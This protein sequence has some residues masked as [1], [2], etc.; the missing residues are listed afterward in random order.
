MNGYS[1][2]E[3]GIQRMLMYSDSIA[4]EQE[5]IE[6]GPWSERQKDP[7]SASFVLINP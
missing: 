5:A 2:I 3:I 6:V 4:I 1:R 7:L